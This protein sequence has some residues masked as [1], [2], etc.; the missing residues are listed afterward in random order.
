MELLVQGTGILIEM[1]ALSIFFSY[2]FIKKQEQS[3]WAILAFCVYFL[4][5]NLLILFP[6]D[7][8]RVGLIVIFIC[9]FTLAMVLYQGEWRKKL[10]LSAFLVTMIYA[11]D[12]VMVSLFLNLFIKQQWYSIFWVYCNAYVLTRFAMVFV[13]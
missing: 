11:I 8:Y 2:F 3:N 9:I 4:V 1:Y 6:H 10:I 7:W 12:Y 5:R 13:V